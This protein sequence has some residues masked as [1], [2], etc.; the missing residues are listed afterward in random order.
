MTEWLRE[1]RL[2]IRIS[3][4]HGI[5]RR[6]FVVN[7]FD[8]ALTMM[9]IIIG[10]SV[11]ERAGLVTVISACLGVVVAL[12]MSG[13][14]SAYISETAERKK[15]LA[16]LKEAM[17]DDLN[18]SAHSTA[19]RVVPLLVAL[20]NGAAP[21]LLGLFIILPLWLGLEGMVLPLPPLQL[22]LLLSL[23]SLFLLGIFLGRI[24]GGF[25]LWSGLQTLLIACVTALLIYLLSPADGLSP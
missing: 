15:W 23:L 13:F 2:L 24:S 14:T 6:Y 1:F 3:H 12:G 4:S 16:E 5:L 21:F 8:G 17:V 7:G 22:S 9:G 20:V 11:G 19:A 18:D 10:F 25:W